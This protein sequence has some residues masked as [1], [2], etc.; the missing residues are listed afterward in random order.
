MR[1]F[2]AAQWG[3][4]SIEPFPEIISQSVGNMTLPDMAYSSIR[5]TPML[6]T[7]P[8]PF[9]G[10]LGYFHF[11]YWATA[12]DEEVDRYRTEMSLCNT[13]SK[14]LCFQLYIRNGLSDL[15][16]DYGELSRGLNFEKDWPL[17]VVPTFCS[18]ES[19][20]YCVNI[21]IKA[22][23]K[24]TL[25]HSVVVSIP[26]LTSFCMG[27]LFGCIERRRLTTHGAAMHG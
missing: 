21:K 14:S 25:P 16:C 17:G 20:W 8:G 18:S 26:S 5:T 7:G 12:D 22:W 1:D 9:K 19:I 24:K 15:G 13:F 11:P 23:F 10:Y 3:D 2:T 27:N 6:C 4:S